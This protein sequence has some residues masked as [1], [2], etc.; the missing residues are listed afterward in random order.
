MRLIGLREIERQLE[1]AIASNGGIETN[2]DIAKR[3]FSSPC[4]T[5]RDTTGER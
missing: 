2:Q 1:P 5:R 4:H 3:H